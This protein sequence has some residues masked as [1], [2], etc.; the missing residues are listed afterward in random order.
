MYELWRAS[1]TSDRLPYFWYLAISTALCVGTNPTQ[2][3]LVRASP[4]NGIRQEREAGVKMEWW[5]HLVLASTFWMSLTETDDVVASPIG[6]WF[7]GIT[8]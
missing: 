5:R 1:L 2:P 4:L 6:P 8:T 3:T 7:N